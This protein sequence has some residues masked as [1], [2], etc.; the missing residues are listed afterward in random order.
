M[1]M[2]GEN[3]DE[4]FGLDEYDPYDPFE[5]EEEEEQED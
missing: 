3:Y 4:R 5:G 1:T 2:L